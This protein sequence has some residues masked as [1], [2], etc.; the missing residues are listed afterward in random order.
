MFYIFR[1][2]QNNGVGVSVRRRRRCFRYTRN[3]LMGS[4]HTERREGGMAP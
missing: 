2:Q 3:N 4:G 1:S